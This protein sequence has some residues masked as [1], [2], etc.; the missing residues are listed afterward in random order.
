MLVSPLEQSINEVTFAAFE[1]TVRTGEM[2]FYVNLVTKKNSVSRVQLI[3][4][5]PG[6][7]ISKFQVV[8][9]LPEFSYAQ[10]QLPGSGSY[11]VRSD[12]NVVVYAYTF[13]N[14]SGS[15]EGYGYSGGSRLENLTLDL[16]PAIPFPIC[17]GIENTYTGRTTIPTTFFQWDFGDGTVSPL[18]SGATGETTYPHTYRKA[19]TYNIRLLATR[20]GS[21]TI[22]ERSLTNV[23]VTGER[24]LLNNDTTICVG[25]KLPLR[26]KWRPA[27]LPP[28]WSRSTTT[29]TT[30]AT[31]PT[32]TSF[33]ATV[34]GVYEVYLQSRF[35]EPGYPAPCIN[36]DTVRIT[37]QSELTLSAPVTQICRG[38]STTLTSNRAAN[39]FR[40]RGAVQTALAT[41]VSSLSIDFPVTGSDTI[42]IRDGVCETRRVVQAVDPATIVLPDVSGSRSV[43]PGDR[44]TFRA[45]SPALLPIRWVR[46]RGATIDTIGRDVIQPA[47]QTFSTVGTEE[48][49]LITCGTT[50]TFT[51]TVNAPPLILP[52]RNDT[53]VCAGT[54]PFSIGGGR[55]A[56]WRLRKGSGPDVAYTGTR[57]TQNV[58]LTELGDYTLTADIGTC[59]DQIRITVVEKRPEITT[60]A[61][62]LERCLGASGVSFTSVSRAYWFRVFGGVRTRLDTAT[63]TT[64]AISFAQ[65]GTHLIISENCAGKDT[66]RV[67]VAPAIAATPQPVLPSVC[68]FNN[69]QASA[70][71]TGGAAPLTYTWSGTALTTASPTNRASTGKLQAGTATLTI[72][73]AYDCT[74]TRSF[75]ITD[76]DEP[77]LS[78]ETSYPLPATRILPE[79]KLDVRTTSDRGTNYTINFGDG[80]SVNTAEAS[81]SYEVPGVYQVTA[82][83]LDTADCEQTI[84]I[85]E[86]TILDQPG[87]RIPNVFTPNGDGTN[88]T[89]D[90]QS[91]ELAVR[92]YRILIFDRSGRQLYSGSQLAPGWNGNLESG[93]KAPA[94]VYFYRV[95]LTFLN[96]RT[97]QRTGTLSLLR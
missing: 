49:L 82:T 83:V 3:P 44:L 43:C 16:R 50:R 67:D 60:P 80:T 13:G 8:P 25:T 33:S 58:T 19:G 2:N 74:E 94:G 22:E 30:L 68:G 62:N 52:N 5:V 45:S 14:T 15:F 95:E 56:A 53:I 78:A 55:L 7:V 36:Y 29:G 59:T 71:V 47:Q 34:P 63:A 9:G 48:I 42:V 65:A 26:R 41:S 87:L 39:W 31:V 92:T 85:G 17:T 72:R 73:D 11:T 76:L 91:V 35:S 18:L 57:A 88:E 66:L 86:V 10:V 64:S 37:V 51:V 38:G 75:T 1:P 61:S 6:G 40:K 32:D 79:T 69:G 77:T 90:V 21:C 81:H 54:Y 96:G 27:L 97:L 20:A 4:D 28:L 46:R 23:V 93:E 70:T 84:S 12:S 89:F 24:I